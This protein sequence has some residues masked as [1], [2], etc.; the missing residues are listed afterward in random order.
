MKGVLLLT[1]YIDFL[2]HRFFSILRYTTQLVL[3]I[4]LSFREAFY[5]QAQGLRAVIRVVSAQIYF[6]GW[7]AIPL[8]T[9]LALATGGTIIMQSTSQMN[10]FG[11]GNLLGQLLVV[12][13]V[14]EVS[15]LLTALIVIARSG[16]AVASELGK[17]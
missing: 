11:S 6:T 1:N 9:I 2:G 16:T 5:D 4:Y 15:P 17:C 7:Q 12:V 3:M 8:I 14:R 10:I 13:I